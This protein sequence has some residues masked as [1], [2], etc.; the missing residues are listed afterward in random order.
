MIWEF[1]ENLGKSLRILENLGGGRG[2]KMFFVGALWVFVNSFV[3]AFANKG[4]CK[5][6]LHNVI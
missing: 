2:C 6:P 5:T 3:G 1:L 4:V